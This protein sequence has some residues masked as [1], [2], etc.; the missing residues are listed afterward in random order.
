MDV[1]CL[2]ESLRESCSQVTLLQQR[3]HERELEHQR[4]AER[5]RARERSTQALKELESRVQALVEQGLLQMR[6]SP[7]GHLDLQVVPA[8][9]QKGQFSVN[10]LTHQSN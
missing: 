1:W 10:A 2:Q 5:E 4:E 6:R 9:R 8:I 7:S 3:E